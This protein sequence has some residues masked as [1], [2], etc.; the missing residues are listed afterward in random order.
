MIDLAS[1]LGRARGVAIAAVVLSFLMVLSAVPMKPFSDAV[2]AGQTTLRIGM[3]EPIDSLNPQIGIN[4]NAYV[5][6]GLVYDFLISV[7]D[8]LGP[9]PNLAESWYRVPDA[10]PYGSVWQYNLTHNAMWHDGE[11]F[12]AADVVFTMS[13][14]TDLNWSTMW[15]Y[16]PYTLLIDYAEAVDPY[17]VRIHFMNPDTG[18]PTACT[19]GDSLMIP[20]LPE[21]IWK[22]IPVA[23]GAFSYANSNPV[24]TGPFMCTE[25]IYD[26]F[27]SGN[28]ITLVR[29]PDYHLEPVK[30]DR[31][32]LE[33]Y[34]EATAMVIDLQRGAIDLAALTAPSYANLLAW[35][36][37]HP[38]AP[39][40]T[41]AGLTCTS[42]SIDIGTCMKYNSDPDYNPLRMDPAVMEAMALAT[43]KEFIRDNIYM[44]FAE[45]GYSLMSPIYGGLYWEPNATERYDYSIEEANQILDAAGYTVDSDGIRRCAPDNPYKGFK[46]RLELKIL[47][48]IELPED[49]ATA[50]FLKDEW[51]EIGID[52]EVD[53]VDA[54]TWNNIVYGGNYDLC[55]SYWSG[56][57]DPNY[58]IYT[59]TE[60]ALEGWSENWYY[61]E[62]YDENYTKSVL[63]LD[64]ASRIQYVKNCEKHTYEDKAWIVTVYPYGC[65]GWREDH[66]TGWGDWG[67]DPGR[68]LANFWSANQLFFDLEP[69]STNEP[70][71]VLFDL[72][73]GVNGTAVQVTA[74]AWDPE[75][76]TMTYYLDYGDD[77]NL[78]GD[79]PEDGELSLS[80]T[81]TRAATYMM[82]LTVSDPTTGVSTESYAIIVEDGT[83]VPPSNIRLRPSDM[84]KL[85]ADEEMDYLITAKDVDGDP[86]SVDVCWDDGSDNY[87]VGLS[88]TSSIQTSEVAHTYGMGEYAINVTV[89][90]G[91]YEVTQWFVLSVSDEKPSGTNWLVIVVAAGAVAAVAV[92][93]T[94]LWK[95]R[96]AKE[97]EDVRLP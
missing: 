42:Y 92:V 89:D 34:L 27:L 43:D 21:H 3:M 14:Q 61:S 40:G 63:E 54:G 59:Q 24:G 88:S 78:T 32:I 87:S 6:Y 33:F 49:V 11:P 18:V 67:L 79:V 77:T 82:N 8:D 19:F 20:I 45:V 35:L 22:S 26:E 4:D 90:D 38:S 76:E 93:A 29:N 1:I 51:R 97:E 16:Q 48:E 64:V 60:K 72:A 7:N 68:Q 23:Q 30:F 37:S 57:P 44:G 94:M 81:Y 84:S 65:Y 5:F 9:K 52:L 15:A 91:T 73:A 39:I 66:F 36:E 86:L 83:N 12:T 56:D 2:A 75:G 53:L 85:W 17:T 58:I 69:V 95:R 80:H 62:E 31:L 28:R 47:V 46:D 70:P 41:Y 25:R 10:V 55:I 50:K 71:S 96:G 74:W 13:Y